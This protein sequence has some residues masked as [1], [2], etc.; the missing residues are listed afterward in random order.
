M[1]Q[2]ASANADSS[3]SP[4]SPMPSVQP[5]GAHP[6]APSPGRRGRRGAEPDWEARLDAFSRLGFS[7]AQ[8][9]VALCIL[10]LYIGSMW[11][12]FL[13]R[14]DRQWDR[15]VYLFTGFEAIVF[16]AAGAIFGTRVQRASVE[17]ANEQTRRAREDLGVE[18]ERAARAARLEE[19]TANFIRALKAYETEE[20][21]GAENDREREDSDDQDRIGPRGRIPRSA[22]PAGQSGLSFAIKLAEDF[23][24]QGRG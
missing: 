12:M 17:A 15:M 5:N 24:P 11:L 16:V 6:P 2:T 10:G 19:A 22:P 1:T 18:R 7:A 21:T 3:T 20:P 9:V 4:N 8:F 14:D 23:F 13:N